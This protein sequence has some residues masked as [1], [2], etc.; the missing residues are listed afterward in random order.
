M[1]IYNT[2]TQKKEEFKTIYPSKVLMYCCGPT[3]YDLLHIGNFR[4]AVFYNFLKLWLGHLGYKVSFY[5]N[6]TDV[7][8]KIIQR[9]DQEGMSAESV[10]EKYIQEFFKDFDQLKLL[11]HDGNPKATEFISSMIDFIQTLIQKEKAYAVDG[12]VFYSVN[13]FKSY[14]KLSRKKLSDL[15]S[16]YR[17]EVI[18]SKKNPLDFVLWKPSK[19]HELGWDSP[20]GKGRPGWH[21]E[22]V[23]MIRECLGPKIDIHGGGLDL[24]FP[25][26][27]NE[28]AQAE[29]VSEAPFVKYWV[30]HNM[31]EFGGKKISKSLGTLQTM[32]AFLNEYNG[33][34]FKYLVFSAH[35][36]SV[37]EIS[38][39]TIHQ[40]IAALFRVYQAL[41][42]AQ[43]LLDLSSS[44][45]KN[46]IFSSKEDFMKTLQQTRS[47]V[48]ESLNDDLNTAKALG[49]CFSL[50]RFF[51]ESIL[52]KN[53][54]VLSEEDRSC[55]SLFLNFFKEYGSLFSL[56]QEKHREFLDELNNILIKKSSLS[57][58]EIEEKIA[59]RQEA[60][61]KKDFA[62]ADSIRQAL[63]NHGV[64]I[65]DELHHTEWNMRPLFFLKD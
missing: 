22:C 58:V 40:A 2:Q 32:R 51:N 35:Y 59:L 65:Q 37:S 55:L 3:V 23:T 17:V 24:L 21:T 53:I 18:K 43:K 54:K 61:A 56:F 6:L 48:D 34:V 16:G 47:Q 44:S 10:G 46:V 29:C 39:N 1:W 4:G 12:H 30:H 36:R 45:K 9:A 52:R 62:Q 26:H 33:E 31:F 50:I 15:Q 49:Y 19:D 41:R 63:N 25:H 57:R 11:S 27:E 38:P 28:K 14:G 60:R 8:D 20:W 7:D 13:S 64:E 42:Q 5:Y